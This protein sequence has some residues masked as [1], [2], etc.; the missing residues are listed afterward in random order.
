MVSN[1]DMMT[2]LY[3]LTNLNPVMPEENFTIIEA[4]YLGKADRF[5][6]AIINC[7][8]SARALT[9]EEQPFGYVIALQT[10]F[11]LIIEHFENEEKT[12]VKALKM[13]YEELNDMLKVKNDYGETSDRLISVSNL[14]TRIGMM[15]GA[16]HYKLHSDGVVNGL[17]APH[18]FH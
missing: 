4:H 10:I 13:L 11:P 5:S 16:L 3:V 12:T 8:T 17:T 1:E 14:F 6:Q 18:T 15:L 2:G 7:V 9:V